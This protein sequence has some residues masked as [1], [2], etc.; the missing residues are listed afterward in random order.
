MELIRY[1]F[2]FLMGCLAVVMVMCVVVMVLYITNVTIEEMFKV[3]I[4]EKIVGALHAKE[5][6]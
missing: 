1:A 3:N 2:N 6:L 5:K 4:A